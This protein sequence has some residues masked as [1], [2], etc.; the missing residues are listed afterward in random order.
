[1]LCTAYFVH[2][3]DRWFGVAV[4]LHQGSAVMPVPLP[5]DNLIR[6]LNVGHTERGTLMQ[7]TCCRS[8][9][10]RCRSLEKT[11]KMAVVPT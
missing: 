6:R 1:M 3:I 8:C 10:C 4:G 11:G 2:L 7:A 9:A 5:D